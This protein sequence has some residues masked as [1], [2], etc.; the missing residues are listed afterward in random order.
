[1]TNRLILGQTG[2]TLRHIPMG[3]ASAVTVELEDLSYSPDDSAN[4]EVTLGAPTVASWSITTNAIAGPTQTNGR[5]VS[6]S[7][8][9]GATIGGYAL[10]QA[11]DGTREV[12][13]IRAVSANSYIEAVSPLAGVY[14]SGSTVYGIGITVT[15]DDTFTADEDRFKLARPLRVTWRYTLDGAKRS[16]PE[17]VE[18]VR[19]EPADQYVAEAAVW[20]GKAYPDAW[21]RL[22]DGADRDIIAKLMADEVRQDLVARNIEPGSFLVSDR[23]R[24]LL[25]ARIVAHLTDLGWSP[26][27]SDPAVW[28]DRAHRLYREKLL[29]LTIGEPGGLTAISD[30]HTDTARETPSRK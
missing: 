8:T 7:S 26:G 12:F 25:V 18:W 20:V 1:M 21:S 4:R 27:G 24:G 14:P 16:I 19:H 23:G 5:R 29:G 10:I 22:P 30:R 28:A 2:Q 3:V 17:F 9:T 13:E 6:A 15:V 11:P